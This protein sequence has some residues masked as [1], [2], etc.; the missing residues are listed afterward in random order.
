MIKLIEFALKKNTT[1]LV[2]LIDCSEISTILQF[3][4]T[5]CHLVMKDKR[6]YVV[7][8]S[9]RTLSNR[10][11]YALE[12][13]LDPYQDSIIRPSVMFFHKIHLAEPDSVFFD[14]E[15]L[16]AFSKALSIALPK[17]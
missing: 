16:K 15:Q 8:G 3:N 5:S 10:F 13:K 9:Y 4:K 7:P 6:V 1:Y 12:A 17:N 2:S 11:L 14:I